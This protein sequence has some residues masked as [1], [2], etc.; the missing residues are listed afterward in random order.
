VC[1]AVVQALWA[2]SYSTS[3]VGVDGVVVRLAGLV[4]TGPTQV[5]ALEAGLFDYAVT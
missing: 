4:R 2:L 5:Q 1:G 3:T